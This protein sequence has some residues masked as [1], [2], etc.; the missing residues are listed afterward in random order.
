MTDPPP[1][2]VQTIHATMIEPASVLLT[3]ESPLVLNN[4]ESIPSFKI[5][6]QPI[7]DDIPIPQPKTALGTNVTLSNLNYGM[8]YNC[9]IW[10]TE[11]GLFSLPTQLTFTTPEKGL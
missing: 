3:W 4:S 8:T 7:L 9:L 10:T 1:D 11:H 6:C 5:S 2:P